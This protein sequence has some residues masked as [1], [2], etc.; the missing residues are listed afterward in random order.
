MLVAV[1]ATFAVLIAIDPG[2]D[3][4]G[5]PQGPGVTLDE[6]FNQEQGVRLTRV[7]P[8]WVRGDLT[9]LEA[10]GDKDDLGKL[11][12]PAGYHL[13]DHPPLGRYWL[14][15]WHN[16]AS[17]LAPPENHPSP[18]VTVCART[19]SAMAFGLTVFLVGFA[20]ARWYGP[21]TGGMAACALAL[22][23]RVFGHAHLAALETVMGLTFTAAV[24]GMAACWSG[25][26]PPS[27]KMAALTGVLMGLAFLTKIQAVLLLVPVIGWVL[28]RFRGKAVIPL[29]IWGGTGFV[30]FFCGW[31]WL[32]IDPWN[33]LLQYAQGATD[34]VP[35]KV[36][37][38]GSVYADG[39]D[40]PVPWHYACVMFLVTVPVLI[41]VLG[42][43]G[44]FGWRNRESDST[45]RH[46]QKAQLL[47]L[48]MCVAFPL[49]LFSLPG[50]T[51]YDG[52]RLFLVI[53]PLWA[54]IVG[55][56]GAAMF[57][58]I[59]ERWSQR[60]AVVITGCVLTLHIVSQALMQPC[61][62][63]YYNLAVGGLNGAERLGLEP[64]YWGDSI[65]RELLDELAKAVPEGATVDVAPVLH[66]FQLPTI[67]AQSPILRK[68]G[69]RLR[70]YDPKK[71][72]RV[73]YLMVFR[74]RADLP[75]NLDPPA[76]SELIAEVRRQGVLLAA[77][78]RF[79]E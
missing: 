46:R 63:S 78:Y 53:F 5:M 9:L 26:S 50:V 45:V 47:L 54:I 65:S 51:V 7:V 19:G 33:H 18:F 66:Q 32:W 23:P 60:T 15:T 12:H 73:K 29:L 71:N 58:A 8:T 69:I 44:L 27:K 25:N 41:H 43:L 76:N 72:D 6:M 10:F 57:R 56:G 21:L 62:L 68:H 16:I 59:H 20:A 3:Y 40:H 24:I 77:L 79:K 28:I 67:L 74:R 4:P 37:Y 36:F 38:F 30:V 70:A 42:G 48:A 52:T 49:I 34:R 17:E 1:L 75:T 39:G 22:M 35:L 2:G 31:P 55:K 13:P 61:F 14:G 11:P 64:T